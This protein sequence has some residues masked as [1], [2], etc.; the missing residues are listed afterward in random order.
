MQHLASAHDNEPTEVVPAVE[1]STGSGGRE[2]QPYND[3]EL[4]ISMPHV[5]L[6]EGKNLLFLAATKIYIVCIL[7]PENMHEKCTL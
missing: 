3:S 2:L 6:N 4:A 5:M 7:S 1:E